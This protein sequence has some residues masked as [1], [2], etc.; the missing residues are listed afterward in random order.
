M[1]ISST[2]LSRRACLGQLAKGAVAL[3]AL[4]AAPFSLAQARAAARDKEVHVFSKHLQWLDYTEMAKTAAKIGFDGVDLTVR[5]GGHVLPENVEKDLPKAVKAIEKAGL[6]ATMITTSISDP[7][8]PH[9]EKILKTAGKLGIRYYRMAWLPY[10]KA[11]SI[12]QNLERYK[13]RMK[14]LA[15]MNEHH[16]MHGAYQNH[17]G[18]N[19]GGSVWDI[20]ELIKDLDPR[21]LGCQFDIRH[22]TVEGG[23]S[24]PVLLRL[25]H[26][27]ILTL[28]IKDFLWQQEA[29]KWK[30][31]N[32]PMGA[33]MV[34]FGA[35]FNLLDELQ[36][37]AAYS[38][39]YEYALGGAEHGRAELSIKPE[40]VIAAME[41]DLRFL[42]E[43]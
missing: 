20:W 35:F 21:W 15:Q 10:E 7:K 32:V 22:A 4:S 13:P 12:P 19:V 27:H 2:F 40:A 24:W 9:T 42:R 37:K 41:K 30:P 6:K 14:E 38:L 1:N 43:L 18:I 31:A 8:D 17:A 36:V 16:G 25:I 5:P 11:Y 34:D 23:T 39:H 29:G 26:S 33:G 3:S 28:D